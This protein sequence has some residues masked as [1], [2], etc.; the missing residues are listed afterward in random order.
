[1]YVVFLYSVDARPSRWPMI[2]DE[3][4]EAANAFLDR[5]GGES[6]FEDCRR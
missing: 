3:I 2:D 1:M 5:N 6:L 4:A